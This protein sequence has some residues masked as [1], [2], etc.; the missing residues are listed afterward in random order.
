MADFIAD[1]GATKFDIGNGSYV[2]VLPI[3]M[4]Q[5]FIKPDEDGAP[6]IILKFTPLVA[7]AMTSF[8]QREL[9][10]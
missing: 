5:F 7:R 8:L 9:F 6:W 2:L 10:S 4:S 3:G 1:T